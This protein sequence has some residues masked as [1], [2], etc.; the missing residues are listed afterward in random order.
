MCIYMDVSENR[1]TPKSSHFNR[2]FHYKPSILGYP[3]FRKHPYIYVCVFYI[4]KPMALPK[5]CI[6]GFSIVN[7]IPLHENE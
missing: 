6:S 7:R 5:H 1:G 3:Y 2:V 4:H